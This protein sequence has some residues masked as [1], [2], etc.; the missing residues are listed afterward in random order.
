MGVIPL[1]HWG[2]Q[3]GQPQHSPVTVMLPFLA[4]K[5]I[6]AIFLI[7]QTEL[8]LFLIGKQQL[9][10]F[11]QSIIK[12]DCVNCCKE[13]SL[14]GQRTLQTHGGTQELCCQLCI[15]AISSS[16]KSYRKEGTLTWC[17]RTM[18]SFEKHHIKIIFK[19][20]LTLPLFQASPHPI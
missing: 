12:S 15:A 14:F 13:T 10:L 6:P 3:P 11:S 19:A 5:L 4:I 8:G 7:K 1:S 2:E 17:H 16:N 9:L 20:I 18:L